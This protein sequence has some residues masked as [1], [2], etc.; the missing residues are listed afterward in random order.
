MSKLPLPA[1]LEQDNRSM[2]QWMEDQGLEYVVTEKKQ[3][4]DKLKCDVKISPSGLTFS[5][6]TIRTIGSTRLHFGIRVLDGEK[7]LLI[8]PAG[9]FDFSYHQVRQY[10]S[11]NYRIQNPYLARRMLKEGLAV[12]KYKLYKAKGGFV[13]KH[14]T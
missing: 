3:R 14:I 11:P 2:K 7:V 5:A 8:K 13:A 12:G 6:K 1:E 9:N 10:D 4:R